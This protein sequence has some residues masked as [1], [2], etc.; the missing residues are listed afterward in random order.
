[1]TPF[2]FRLFTITRILSI[3]SFHVSITKNDFTSWVSEL[4]Y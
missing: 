3:F 2:E 1:L 4:L